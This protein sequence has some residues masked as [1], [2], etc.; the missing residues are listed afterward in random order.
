[1]HNSSEYD[2]KSKYAPHFPK[3]LFPRKMCDEGSLITK[4]F[5]GPEY[6][7]T[8]SA[9][10]A[11]TQLD[12]QFFPLFGSKKEEILKKLDE[13]RSFYRELK[14]EEYIFPKDKVQKTSG[15]ILPQ[16]FKLFSKKFVPFK[17]LEKCVL[18]NVGGTQICAPVEITKNRTFIDANPVIFGQLIDFLYTGKGHTNPLF[19]VLMYQLE[20]EPEKIFGLINPT[21][22]LITGNINFEGF[23]LCDMRFNRCRF[24]D[25]NNFQQSKFTNCAIENTY[26]KNCNLSALVIENGTFRNVRFDESRI[27]HSIWFNSK[28]A[29]IHFIDCDLNHTKF[30]SIWAEEI[31]FENCN[32]ND[33]QIIGCVW[34]KLT[35]LHSKLSDVIFHNCTINNA[36]LKYSTADNLH[37]KECK[38]T[39]AEMQFS[40]A[41]FKIESS[42]CNSIVYLEKSPSGKKKLNIAGKNNFTDARMSNVHFS[43]ANNSQNNFKDAILANCDMSDATLNNTD[44]NNAVL[45]GANLSHSDLYFANLE[46]ADLDGVNLYNTQLNEANLQFTSMSGVLINKNTIFNGATMTGAIIQSDLFEKAKKDNMTELPYHEEKTLRDESLIITSLINSNNMKA[47]CFVLNKMYH[48]YINAQFTHQPYSGRKVIKPRIEVLF[49]MTDR[50]IEQW[51]CIITEAIYQLLPNLPKK[52]LSQNK[53]SCIEKE[54]TYKTIEWINALS[55]FCAQEKHRTMTLGFVDKTSLDEFLAILMDCTREYPEIWV[56]CFRVLNTILAFDGNYRTIFSNKYFN[57]LEEVYKFL[58]KF[59]NKNDKFE[60]EAFVCISHLFMICP[61]GE[62]RALYLNRLEFR[63]YIMTLIDINTYQL[64]HN[65][66]N[67]SADQNQPQNETD[68]QNDQQTDQQKQQNDQQK[69]QNDKPMLYNPFGFNKIYFENSPYMSQQL[70]DVRNKQLEI[71]NSATQEHITIQNDK[72]SNGQKNQQGI[73]QHDTVEETKEKLL[74]ISE[75]MELGVVTLGYLWTNGENANFYKENNFGTKLAEITLVAYKEQ[76]ILARIFICL[77]NISVNNSR[78]AAEIS[79]DFF[80]MIEKLADE[81]LLKEMKKSKASQLTEVNFDENKPLKWTFIDSIYFAIQQYPDNLILIES[82]LSALMVITLFDQDS[83]KKFKNFLPL[84]AEIYDKHFQSWNVMQY[85]C[86]CIGNAG[87]DVDIRK[88]IVEKG[89]NIHKINAIGD[90]GNKA[91]AVEGK[92]EAV[93][94]K[95]IFSVFEMMDNIFKYHLNNGFVMQYACAMIMSLS[96]TSEYQIAIKEKFIIH[97]FNAF[98]KHDRIPAVCQNIF[99]AIMSLANNP[100]NQLDLAKMFASGMKKNLKTHEKIQTVIEWGLGAILC[101]CQNNEANKIIKDLQFTDFIKHMA[102]TF[103][104]NPNIVAW[105][106]R[107]LVKI[108]P[109]ILPNPASA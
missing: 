90:I 32:M 58:F 3:G 86:A 45:R 53:Q 66:T 33:S 31:T 85:W 12:A 91:E 22:G 46:N 92:A 79:N 106:R 24:M 99:S 29:Q 73:L 16:N 83:K 40:S 100:A 67:Q 18:V 57:F 63:N 108:Q 41:N 44:F 93:E 65:P 88:L 35:V 98:E 82:G 49:D 95:Q 54:T 71:K 4:I 19:Y 47:L 8:F 80:Q 28:M 69:Q 68:Q 6:F 17:Y 72:N 55:V 9:T 109:P 75:R 84:F 81:K 107:I 97:I 30:M 13:L 2:V 87:L 96:L 42:N 70:I 23:E 14:D 61:I 39:G 89:L 1:M 64:T 50:K 11:D 102:E 38:M 51:F 10:I 78:I 36:I 7:E 104:N 59:R 103:P 27:D 76:Y 77:K 62:T 15:V 21:I 74:R 26:F 105:S 37:F 43:F 25:G 34:K 56:A 52:F 48:K 60:R 5:I 101:M 20:L 94:G